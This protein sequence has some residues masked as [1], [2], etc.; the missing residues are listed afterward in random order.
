MKTRS[1]FSALIFA[2]TASAI[3]ANDAESSDSPELKRA[4]DTYDLHCGLCHMADGSGAGRMSPPIE[5]SAL[6]AGDPAPLIDLLLHG[7]DAVLPKPRKKYTSVMLPYRHLTDE[8]LADVVTY[9]RTQLIDPPAGA[10]TPVQIA[11]RRKK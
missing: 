2:A 5:G 6:V 4:R 1:F 8:Q 10:V 7:P 9:M 11:E 3:L